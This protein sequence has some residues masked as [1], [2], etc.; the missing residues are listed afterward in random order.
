MDIRR[1]NQKWRRHG[2]GDRNSKTKHSLVSCLW[3]WRRAEN[4]PVAADAREARRAYFTY[5]FFFWPFWNAHFRYQHWSLLSTWGYVSSV[6]CLNSCLWQNSLGRRLHLPTTWP[7]SRKAVIAAQ[8]HFTVL[9][10]PLDRPCL[11]SLS[12]LLN[13]LQTSSVLI[14]TSVTVLPQKESSTFDLYI[15]QYHCNY[16]HP[17]WLS[18]FALVSS[19][20][21]L[22]LILPLSCSIPCHLAAVDCSC[23]WFSFHWFCKD[24]LFNLFAI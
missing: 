2:D 17:F 9:L 3:T 12:F 10:F 5:F 4:R 20:N 14:S 23:F 24:N 11:L 7:W 18:G 16:I 21:L 22:L 19:I 13:S 15:V 1:H 6:L 8:L